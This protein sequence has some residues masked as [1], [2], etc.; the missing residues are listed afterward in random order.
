MTYNFDEP[1]DRQG[2]SSVK[3]DLRKDVF[4]GRCNTDVG[5]RY[6]P[7]ASHSYRAMKLIDH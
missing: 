7:P 2:T 4:G 1:V 6:G 5:G 3:Y